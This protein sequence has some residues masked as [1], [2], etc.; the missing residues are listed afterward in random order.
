MRLH[1]LLKVAGLACAV[2]LMYWLGRPH[3]TAPPPPEQPLPIQSPAPASAPDSKPAPTSAALAPETQAD[4]SMAAFTEWS[5]RYLSADA[6]GRA[7]LVEEGVRLAH[8]RRPAF[9]DLIQA[10]P[11][12]ALAKAVPMVVRQKLPASIVALL[13]ERISGKG[14]LEVLAVSP[15]SDPSEPIYRHIATLGDREWRAYVYGRRAEE[16]SLERTMM[17]GV[18]IDSFMALDESPVRPLEI[19]EIP[20]VTK[21]AVETCPVSGISTAV[22]REPS[23]APPPIEPETPAIEAGDQIIYLCDGG[24]IRQFIEDTLAAEGSTGGPTSA[25]SSLPVTRRNSTGVRR[26]VYMRVIFP[27]RLDECQS[28]KDAW[29]ACR[30]LDEYFRE[31]S[32]GKLSF[33]GTVTPT[34]LLPRTEAS[35]KDAY[36]TTNSNGPIMNDAKQAAREM[37]Y[38]PENFHHF[39]VIYSGGPGSFGGLGSVNGTNTWL[40]STSIGT[41]RHEIGHNIG[42]WH[43]NF[44]NTGGES[45]IGPGRNQ[46][47]GHHQDVMGSSGSGGH[48]NAGMKRIL[49]WLTPETY[50]PVTSSGVYRIHQFDQA[51]QDPDLRYAIEIPKDPEREYWVEFR[52]KLTVPWYANGASINWSSWGR[53]DGN[54]TLAGSNRG[55]QLLDMT[56]GTADDKNDSPLVIGRTFSDYEADV[57]ITPIGKGG[58]TPE[59][60]DVQVH[61]GTAAGNSPPTLAIG[62]SATSIAVGGT[63]TFTATSIDPD[64]DALAYHWNFGDKHA[65]TYHGPTFSTDNSAVQTKTFA[66]AGWYAVQCTVSDMKGGAVRDTVLIQVGTPTTFYISG[67][68]TDT[69]AAPVYDVRVHNG[70]STSSYRGTSTDSDGDYFITNLAAGNHTLSVAAPGYTFAPSG[71]SNPVAVGPNQTGK[72]FTATEARRVFM[73]IVDGTATEGGD[74]A[75][76]RLV[77]TGSTAADEIVYVNLSGTAATADYTLAP[78]ADTALASPLEVFTIP[79]GES[80]LD[81]VLTPKQDTTAE[82]PETLEITLL[83]A[84]DTYLPVGTQTLTLTIDDDDTSLSRVTIAVSDDEAAE[85]TVPDPAVFTVT[86]TGSTA[87]PLT[88]NFTVA[89]GS[90]ANAVA[91]YAVNGTDYTSIGTNVVIP[92]G[93]SSAPIT[94]TPIN[95][96]LVEGIE[97]VQVTLSTNAAYIR[98]TSTAVTAKI[99]DDDIPNVTIAATDATANENG[100]TATFTITRTGSTT[101]PLTV[102]YSSGGDALHGTDYQPLAGYVTIAPGQTTAEVLVIPINDDLGEPAQSIVIQL[103]SASHYRVATPSLATASLVDDGDLPVV[104]L[105]IMD[106]IVAEKSSPDH[107]SFRIT[108]TGTGSGNLT[109]KYQVTGTATSGDDFNALSGTLSIG[110]NAVSNITVTIRNDSIPEDAETIIITL[111]PDASYQLDLTTQGTMVIR[112]DD[113]AQMV[114]VS[115]DLTSITEGATGRFFFARSGTTTSSLDLS[116][117][118]GGT[119]GSSDYTAPSG[120]VT[121]PAAAVGAYVDIVT[122]NDT[123]A[124][125]VE[126]IQVTIDPDTGGTRTYGLE[127][128]S[129][130]LKVLDND[131]GFTNTVAFAETSGTVSEDS[132]TISVPVNRTGGGLGTTSCSVEYAVRFSTAQGAGVDFLAP[133]ARLD[134]APGETVKNIAIEIIDDLLTE[135]VEAI[136]L[137]LRNPTLAAIASATARS[138]VFIRDNEPRISIEATDPFTYELAD[139]AEFR[140]S[141]KGTTVGAL[142]VPLA[143]SGTAVSGVDFTPLPSSVTIPDGAAFTTLTLTTLEN[144]ATNAPLTVELALAPS[145]TSLPGLRSSATATLGDAQSDNPPLLHLV[146]PLGDSPG[147]PSN[148]SLRLVAL[149]DDDTPETLTTTWSKLSGPGTVTFED[150]GAPSTGARFS[151]AGAY[152]LRLTAN[153]GGQSS[154]LDVPLTVGVPVL[155]WTHSNIGT[156]TYAGSAVEQHGHVSLSGGGA[157]LSGSTDRFFFR[158][159][160]LNGDGEV[161]ARVRNV[162]TSNANA[163]IGV[164][165][166]DSTANNSKMAS[167]NLAPA[168]SY[169]S[170]SNRSSYQRRISTSVSTTN[171]DGSV[172]SSWVRLKRAGSV[173]TAYDS[174]DGVNWTQR[175]QDTLP[176]ATNAL[177]GI[178]VTS[179]TTT[180]LTLGEVDNV[181]IV[182][183]PDNNGPLVDAGPAASVIAGSTHTLA[184]TVND[185]ALPDD[186]GAVATTWSLVSG[187]AAPVFTEAENSATSVTFP[188]PGTYTLR[189]AADD[190]EVT[191]SDDVVITATLPSVTVAATSSTAAESGLSPGV[192]TLTRNTTTGDLTVLF[193]ITGTADEGTDYAAIGTSVRIPDGLATATVAVTPL[194]DSIAEGSETVT[195]ALATDPAYTLGSPSSAQVTLLDL[196]AD[197]WL[198]EQFGSEANDPAITDPTADLDFDGLPNLI[199]YAFGVDPQSSEASPVA[200]DSVTSGPDKFMRLIVPKNPAATDVTFTVEATAD[201]A[202]PLSWSSDGLIIESETSTQLIVRDTVPMSSGQRFMRV[203]VVRP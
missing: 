62:T 96:A 30:Q 83:N 24:H 77:R 58:T 68:I 79:A 190:G 34:I 60:L 13:E 129:A 54:S 20:D 8:L 167:I 73:E 138:T 180:D 160:R 191:T 103:R 172:P 25:T 153:D 52:Q 46:E 15:D 80:Q 38:P 128:P 61:I 200:S 63:V 32:Y 156:T 120:T 183:T 2:G 189:L 75:A 166:R 102:H 155:P 93:A 64:G 109:V 198:F 106:G 99:I 31:I 186:P 203:R 69:L 175:G 134:F 47:Y 154:S 85:G 196:P 195:L 65:A 181:R 194:A 48:F 4:A 130:T 56:P 147:V 22:E 9:K 72:N 27:D 42:V 21:K 11:K 161:I 118:M 39:V 123:A 187:P 28:E 88:V 91:A 70:L 10:D 141:R 158:H 173:F 35:Y 17:N 67:T 7:A 29:T 182:G 37:G 45:T 90:P 165:I 171:A 71:F 81:V 197:H 148:V 126:T 36:N 12:D 16:M 104:S 89:T 86:R 169:S 116:Y 66:T 95:D 140:I 151:T 113:A 26:F 41:F 51:N 199:E 179:G 111:L 107:G 131:S 142:V 146:S 124:E 44:W 92:A 133:P 43:S 162:L 55:T 18:G 108:T 122:T 76:F 59:S 5:A 57:H 115:T 49:E 159:R 150:A 184:G 132:G 125:G 100:D 105:N 149:A 127:T 119:A 87:A 101:A 23:I 143:V 163:R 157:A 33:Q 177:A 176:I 53:S 19:G 82:G 170:S 192:F 6:A 117:T 14:G 74:T 139:T 112:D 136:V 40:R 1:T 145:G 174:P 135:G 193:S 50:H 152:T 164:M 144:P 168:A 94:I 84:G 98:G 188:A 78:A 114:S 185:D 97:K 178:A 121:I 110:K 202:D 201:L 137:E 3:G